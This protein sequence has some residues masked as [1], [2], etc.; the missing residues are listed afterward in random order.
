[1]A[2]QTSMFKQQKL[3]SNNGMM[4]YV[5]SVSSCYKQDSESAELVRVEML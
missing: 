2:S 1:M 3:H 5:R 4:F